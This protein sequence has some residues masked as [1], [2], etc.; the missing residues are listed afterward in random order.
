VRVKG[1]TKIR[2]TANGPVEASRYRRKNFSSILKAAEDTPLYRKQV[3]P[4]LVVHSLAD[5]VLGYVEGSKAAAEPPHSK[6]SA[7][8]MVKKS[9]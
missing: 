6:G 4:E 2:A 9:G 5:H 3:A 8:C 1:K 7:R